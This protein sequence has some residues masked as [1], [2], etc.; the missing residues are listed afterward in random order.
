MNRIQPGGF[1]LTEP[2]LYRNRLFWNRF[3]SFGVGLVVGS[4]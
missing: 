4:A 1:R 2:A 3:G